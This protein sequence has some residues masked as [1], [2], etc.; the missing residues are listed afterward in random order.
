MMAWI[1]ERT[2]APIALYRVIA[3]AAFLAW[4]YTA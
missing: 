3:G 1:E 4:F 2:F